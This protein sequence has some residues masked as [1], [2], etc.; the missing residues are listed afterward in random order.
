MGVVEGEEAAEA[1]SDEALP[2]EAVQ[3]GRRARAEA[4]KVDPVIQ[5]FGRELARQLVLS[6]RAYAVSRR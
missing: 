5:A 2:D 1:L 4:E 3:V 6:A